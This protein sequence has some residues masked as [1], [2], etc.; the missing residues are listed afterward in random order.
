MEMSIQAKLVIFFLSLCVITNIQATTPCTPISALPYIIE[1]P[2]S[3]CLTDNLVNNTDQNAITIAASGVVLDLKQFT[4]S[5]YNSRSDNASFGIFSLNCRDITIKNGFIKGFMYGIY[6]SDKLGSDADP[7]SVSGGHVIDNMTIKDNFFRGIRLEGAYNIIKNSTITGVSGTT[8]FSN[9]FAIGIESIGPGA[10]I[11]NNTITE[12]Y[13]TGT[14]ESVALS[15]SNNSSGS[16][17]SGNIINN[18]KSAVQ[19]PAQLNTGEKFGIWIGGNL[20]FQTNVYIR[21]NKISNMTYGVTFAFPTTGWY[22]N[23]DVTQNKRCDY[24][25]CSTSV[26]TFN[27]K[28]FVCCESLNIEQIKVLNQLLMGNSDK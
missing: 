2:G 17:A 19:N 10:I 4:I 1:S 23:N 9:A 18:K 16:S 21:N 26:S 13:G 27:H 15:F 28:G 3:Y 5:S 14:G 20:I 7:G 6:L 11:E 22:G 24:L 25:I 8:V 12:I